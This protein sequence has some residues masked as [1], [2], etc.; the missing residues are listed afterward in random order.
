[1]SISN[2]DRCAPT[3]V[4]DLFFCAWARTV[5]NSAVLSCIEFVTI[6]DFTGEHLPSR[7]RAAAESRRLLNAGTL[8]WTKFKAL[9]P[10]FFI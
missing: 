9:N 10:D 1:M 8:H 2:D 3:L 5:L 6:V 7:T 4:D